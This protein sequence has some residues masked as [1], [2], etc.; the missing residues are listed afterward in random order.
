MSTKFSV[1]HVSRICNEI[2]PYGALS[3]V[4]FVVF[5]ILSLDIIERHM[6]YGTQIDDC[7]SVYKVFTL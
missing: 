4:F 6:T 5:S 7:E 1:S 2:K 3:S